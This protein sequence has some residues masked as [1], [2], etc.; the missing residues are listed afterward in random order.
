MYSIW[1]VVL[2]V[3]CLVVGVTAERSKAF[4]QSGC[5]RNCDADPVAKTCE[6]ELKI[7][8][9]T[10]MSKAC[11]QCPATLSDCNRPH[12]AVADGFARQI[13]T[14]NRQL[15]SPAIRV[16]EGDTIVA[17][18][19]NEMANGEG[20]SIHWHGLHQP[21]TPYMDGVA[22]VTQS[23]IQPYSDFVY[24][25]TTNNSGTHY[26]HAHF[27]MQR[28]DGI[29]GALIVKQRKNRYP[30]Y[31]DLNSHTLLI[32]DWYHK[33]AIGQGMLHLHRKGS[34]IPETFI[35][36]G[37]AHSNLIQ[38]YPTYNVSKGQKYRFRTINNGV[39]NCPIHIHIESH[40]ITI[41]ATDGVDIEEV[42]ADTVLVSGGE[43]WDFLLDADLEAKNYWMV[44]QGAADC[45]NITTYGILH[46]E[47]ARNV[48]TS[49]MRDPTAIHPREMRT[50][51][52]FNKGMITPDPDDGQIIL[53]EM[54]SHEPT[55]DWLSQ[56]PDI[57]KYLL[58]GLNK[59]KDQVY[60]V[61]PY[62]PCIDDDG[63]E[64]ASCTVLAQ[65]N[66]V[67][68]LF[69]S[70]PY[71]THY[72]EVPPELVLEVGGK[73]GKNCSVEFCKYIHRLSVT[74][75]EVVEFILIDRGRYWNISNHPMHIHGQ[76]MY[77]LDL[78]QDPS[79]VTSTEAV[80]MLDTPKRDNRTFDR[81]IAKD[82]IMMPVG[83]Y[84]VVRFKARD[85]GPWLFHCHNELHVEQGMFL[86]IDVK[87]RGPERYPT[88]PRDQISFN[89]PGVPY[90]LEPQQNCTLSQMS[91]CTSLE[92]GGFAAIII[93]SLS[94]VTFLGLLGMRCC[95]Y[96][97][98]KKAI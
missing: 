58:L 6:F 43:R 70:A 22:L 47:G 85:A 78:G 49:N 27:G 19:S 51:N 15:P 41:I 80:E 74:Q 16:C 81:P 4:D 82:T 48:N 30:Q 96:K 68:G 83:G 40:N 18:I 57:R 14:V 98:S 35:I 46:Y 53:S 17:K 89:Q 33:L 45:E 66:N 94:A 42:E 88:D 84:V 1:K 59:V 37:L 87:S 50:V 72:D 73:T 21:G 52:P 79:M 36:N 2:I 86:V 91:T 69:P 7:E 62:Y 90:E 9:Y 12:C 93:A 60:D 32:Q 61:S 54:K 25:F 55:P 5:D 34:N 24:N 13:Y 38:Q 28:G 23:I 67:Y 76:Y 56:Q 10:T 71:I 39:M 44:F 95:G 8:T 26:Y 3:Y 29:A 11:Y 97:F 77:V 64:L 31:Q 20:T 75:G 63:S 92:I 65:I